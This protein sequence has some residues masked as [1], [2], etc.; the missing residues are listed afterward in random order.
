MLSRLEYAD[1]SVILIFGIS[2]SPSSMRKRASSASRDQLPSPI[3]VPASPSS[4][5]RRISDVDND[6]GSNP[7]K[8]IIVVRTKSS[9]EIPSQRRASVQ[10]S[11]ADDQMSPLSARRSV[12][13]PRAFDPF[14]ILLLI[15]YLQVGSRLTAL[16]S[17]YVLQT[18]RAAFFA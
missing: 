16:F 10:R 15:L 1:G 11:G 12:S 5:R 8:G 2:Y 18:G 6:G 9:A 14:V 3:A 4:G 13:S 17:T 7:S